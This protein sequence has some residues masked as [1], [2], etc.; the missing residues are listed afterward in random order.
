MPAC[1][2]PGCLVNFA[3]NDSSVCKSGQKEATEHLQACLLS[4]QEKFSVDCWLAAGHSM[5]HI[6]P[7]VYSCFLG[8]PQQ[9]LHSDPCQSAFGYSCQPHSMQLHCRVPELPAPLLM[10]KQS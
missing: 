1:K 3:P 2:S 9:L 8:A 10:M 5:V 7:H 4:A 6:H